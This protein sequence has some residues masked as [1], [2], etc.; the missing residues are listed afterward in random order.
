MLYSRP[1]EGSDA[2]SSLDLGRSASR[3]SEDGQEVCIGVS[4]SPTCIVS[5][6]SLLE[7]R[8]LERIETRPMKR[9]KISNSSSVT[10]SSPAQQDEAR[11]VYYLALMLLLL[12]S[13]ERSSLC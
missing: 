5:G 8:S 6:E 9:S 12:R 3:W 2:F 1:F 13:D 10:V 4:W 7:C 11:Q